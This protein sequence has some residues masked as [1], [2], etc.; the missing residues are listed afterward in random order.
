[1]RTAKEIASDCL[2]VQDACNLSGVVF[3]FADY[4]KILC[5]V[6][7]ELGKG[8]DWKNHHPICLMFS[9][10]IGHLTGHQK[11]DSGNLSK[12]YDWCFKTKV[13]PHDDFRAEDFLY[14]E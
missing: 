4:M 2:M 14:E 1:M 9:D 7:N 3:S 5:E 12:A 11:L 8:T 6:S 10:K 13:L